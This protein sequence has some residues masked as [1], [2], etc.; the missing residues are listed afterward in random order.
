MAKRESKKMDL[1]KVI[2]ALN[3]WRDK[4]FTNV[5]LVFIAVTDLYNFKELLCRTMKLHD[6][7]I[8]MVN[9]FK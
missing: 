2:L 8:S 5:I 4:F 9:G 6:N 7:G 3:Y 1:D